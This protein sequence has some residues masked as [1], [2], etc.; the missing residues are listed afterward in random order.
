VCREKSEK[1]KFTGPLS[2][3]YTGLKYRYRYTFERVYRYEYAYRYTFERVY[4]Y[5][6]AYRYTFERVYRYEYAYR[7]TFVFVPSVPVQF[8]AIIFSL[9]KLFF[10]FLAD[11]FLYL[12]NN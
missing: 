1:S 10:F 5:E 9:A 7:Y 3:K 12:I 11:F 8:V 4:R 6:Y 2:S